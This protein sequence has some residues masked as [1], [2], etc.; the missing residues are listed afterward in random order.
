[1]KNVKDRFRDLPRLFKEM[2]FKVGAEIGVARGF[3][4]KWLLYGIPGLKLYL[5]DPW[6]AYGEYTE[7]SKE[8]DQPIMD[9]NLKKAK[10]RLKGKNVVFIRKTSMDALEDFED[11]SLDFVFIDGNHSFEYVIADIAGWSKKVRKGGIVSGHDYWN[12]VDRG[13]NPKLCQAKD[14]VDAWTKTNQ[15]K[16]YVADKDKSPSWLWIKQ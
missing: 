2:G 9:A 5:I 1:M 4:S 13:G 6:K 12:S 3:Y 7:H 15:I 8:S 10:E 14:A 11:E 16:F